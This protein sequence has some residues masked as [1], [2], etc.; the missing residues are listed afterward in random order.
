M[1]ER[2]YSGPRSHSSAKC[3][4][5]CAFVRPVGSLRPRVNSGGILPLLPFRWCAAV[6]GGWPT[7][8]SVPGRGA[9]HY[10]EV[11]CAARLASRLQTA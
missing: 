3:T 8:N 10:P 1:E 7:G 2:A 9:Y 4:G 11:P 6:W 5:A